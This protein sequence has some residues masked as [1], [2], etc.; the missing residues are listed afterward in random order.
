[1]HN[2]GDVEDDTECEMPYVWL[3]RFDV[4]DETATEASG[5]HTPQ[6]PH[7]PQPTKSVWC[8]LLCLCPCLLFYE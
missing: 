4:D 1:M 7:T 2:N 8:L 3:E 5:P 6:T